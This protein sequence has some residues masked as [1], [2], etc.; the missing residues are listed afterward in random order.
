MSGPSH[1][2]LLQVAPTASR[3]ELRQAFRLLSKRF[4]PDTTELP[5]AEAERL[6]QQLR[7]AYAV[8]SDPAARERYDGELRHAVLLAAANPARGQARRGAPGPFRWRVASTAAAWHRPGLQPGV[9]GGYG[10]VAGGRADRIAEL[11]AGSSAATQH[12][13]APHPA[14]AAYAY[15][16]PHAAHQF[17]NT[18]LRRR[19]QRRARSIRHGKS[20]GNRAFSD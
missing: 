20:T 9:G 5:L 13:H 12:P 2:Q 14:A 1:Y 10:L 4:H 7:L 17:F 19:D 18:C 3:E 15:P 11:V 6:F 16:G 8:L